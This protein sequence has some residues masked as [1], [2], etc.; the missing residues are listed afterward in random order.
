MNSH[1]PS[2]YEWLKPCVTPFLPRACCR[3]ELREIEA[4]AVAFQVATEEATAW[5]FDGVR[6]SCR[7][8]SLV[9][10]LGSRT[11]CWAPS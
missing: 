8:V 3:R 2:R 6:C 7:V 1:L 4:T 9:V 10:C 11:V 5:E